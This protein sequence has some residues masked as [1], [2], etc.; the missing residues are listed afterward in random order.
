MRAAKPDFQRRRFLSI[1]YLRRTAALKPQGNRPL[2]SM[3]AGC[4]RFPWYSRK[5]LSGLLPTRLPVSSQVLPTLFPDFQLFHW[6]RYLHEK[7]DVPRL[8]VLFE[9]GSSLA[10]QKLPCRHA[11]G[12]QQH[13]SR[14]RAAC[15]RGLP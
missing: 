8:H 2:T 6:V 10:S 3:H 4:W 7:A 9:E 1:D 15:S 11:A 14:T 12:L 5:K 13:P